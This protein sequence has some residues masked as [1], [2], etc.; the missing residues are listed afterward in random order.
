MF[1]PKLRGRFNAEC[2]LDCSIIPGKR[3]GGG[4]AAVSQHFPGSGQRGPAGSCS[5]HGVAGDTPS[6]GEHLSRYLDILHTA[7]YL[8]ILTT[9]PGSVSKYLNIS[10]SEQISD[11]S[12]LLAFINKTDPGS[13]YGATAGWCWGWH[14]GGPTSDHW[15]GPGHIGPGHVMQRS[16]PAPIP[17]PPPPRHEDYLT[18]IISCG[19]GGGASYVNNYGRETF[20]SQ[21]FVFVLSFQNSGKQKVSA[22]R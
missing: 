22:V 20:L 14:L 12:L 10:V 1:S 5:R 2:V 7:I 6:Y 13:S 11:C 17:A 16:D 18:L 19:R 9:S 8:D 21:P 15:A 4:G 3:G